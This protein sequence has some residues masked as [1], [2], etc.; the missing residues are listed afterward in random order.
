MIVMMV[1]VVAAIIMTVRG[2]T[3]VRM[4]ARIVY[5]CAV[6]RFGISVRDPL[7]VLPQEVDAVIISVWSPNDRVRVKLLRFWIV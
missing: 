7:V 3:I 1:M 4:E 5:R 2:V 6:L